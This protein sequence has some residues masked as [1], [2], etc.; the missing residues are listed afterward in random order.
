MRILIVDNFGG[1]GVLDWALRCQADGHKVKWYYTVRPGKNEHMGKGLVER[2]DD[3]RPWA[4]WADLIFQTDNAKHVYPLESYRAQ[5]YPIVGPNL[6]GA[7]WEL[8]RKLGQQILKKNGVPVPPF[9]EFKDYDQAISFVK[10]EGR[11]FVS[12]PC[13]DEEDKSLSYCSKSPADMV[14]MLQRWKRNGRLKSSFLLQDF[15]P[16][17]EMAVGGWFGP[18]GFNAGWC[19]NWEFKKLMAGDTGPATGEMGTVLRF[20]RKSKLADLVLKPLEQALAEIKYCG[21]VDVNTIIDEDGNP[22]PLEFTMRPGWPTY[23]IQQALHTGDHAEWLANLAAGKDMKNFILDRV[24]TGVVMAIPD[25]PYSHITRKEVTGVPI[26]GLTPQ[27]SSNVHPCSVMQGEAPHNVDGKVVNLAGWVTAG[28]YVLIASG[29]GDSV[30][31]ARRRAYSVLKKIEVPASPFWRPDIG[32]RLQK[33]I[34]L[35][36]QKGFARGLSF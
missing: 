3:W 28:D 15:I 7:A 20:V 18:H 9:R 5:G 36:Q 19:E 31:E 16:G 26:Y 34:P 32:Q 12:K 30:Q 22:W 2:V 33:Q 29:T 23:N 4:R 17:T 11:R 10:R 35:I 14:F 21:Y 27:I 25:F 13:G 24:A 1:D 8:D 6:A